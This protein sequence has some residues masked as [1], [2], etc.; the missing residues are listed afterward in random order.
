MQHLEVTFRLETPL[1]LAGANQSKA[2]LRVPSI[3]GALRYWYRAIQPNLA[4]EGKIFGSMQEG[5]SALRLHLEKPKYH[6]ADSQPFIQGNA[7]APYFAFSLKDRAYLPSDTT[8]RLHLHVPKESPSWQDYLASI[9]L[10]TAIGGLGSRTR[11]GYGSISWMDTDTSH[12]EIKKLVELLPNLSRFQTKEEW[13]QQLKQGI[14]KL[15]R[16]FP[17]ERSVTHTI[18]HPDIKLFLCSQSLSSWQ[19]AM[20]TG[21]TIL[22]NFRQG[23]GKEYFDELPRKEIREA[24]GGAG[25]KQRYP[26]PYWLRIVRI[27]EKYFPVY[28]LPK[29][30]LPDPRYHSGLE[31]FEAYICENGFRMEVFHS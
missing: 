3:K 6:T 2:E 20:D 12:D 22:K 9:W 10:L 13:L 18:I 14:Q 27:G 21:A 28:F 19:K 25:D 31:M 1:Y 16:W 5:Q 30:T 15:W 17:P 8:F 29:T 7:G 4:M 23:Q 24:I 26:S 11:R